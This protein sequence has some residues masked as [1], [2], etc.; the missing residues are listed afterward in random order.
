VRIFC[1][2]FCFF[3]PACT[4]QEIE[5]K[6]ATEVMAKPSSEQNMCKHQRTLFGQ[7]L[8]L[9][10]I[11]CWLVSCAANP[12][13]GRHEL[14]LLSEDDESKLGRK[15]DAQ[16][17]E[18]YGLYR[19]PDLGAYIE[20]LGSGIAKHSHRSHLSFDFKVLDSST[21]NAFAV[22]GGYVYLTRGILSYLN[23]EA[24][25]V[26][27]IAHE[28]GHVAARHSAQQY[29]RAQLSQLGLGVG[30]IL[31]E[32][33]RQYARV[34]QFG[35]GMLFLKFSRDNE[36]QADELA[37]EYATKA[38][39]D[40]NR[41]ASFFLTLQRLHPSSD[42]SGLPN[43]FSTHP[44]P[45]DRIKSI[46]RKA[47]EWAKKSGRPK[48]HVNRDEYLLRID[49]LVLGEDPRQGYLADNTFYH[50]ELTF[51]FPV[52]SG[53]KL[54]NTP[55][56]IQMASKK[57]DAVIL[58]SPASGTS[59]KAAAR[60]FIADAQA[61]VLAFDA[62]T[63]NGLPAQRII[64]DIA[65]QQGAIRVMS[66]FI[67]KNA[68]IYVFHAFTA[69]PLFQ[70]YASVFSATLGG[71]K[72]LTDPKKINVK[73]DRLII[74][75]TKTTATLRQ[76]LEALGVPKED[77]EEVSVLNGR[78]LHDRIPADTLL[79]I[80]AGRYRNF[81]QAESKPRYGRYQSSRL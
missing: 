57:Q 64:A 78:P 26:G 38:G 53:W 5:S 22:P 24:E 66:Y 9:F 61:Q 44:D 68:R 11:L 72:T 65:T 75:A 58:F 25:L 47:R 46:Q 30:S 19:D 3:V 42:R 31:S 6:K 41:M 7:S 28:I 79:K 8:V 81:I 4:G 55:S 21:V 62:I 17:A 70:R 27:V 37:V 43:W 71:F 32:S 13:T 69:P 2:S 80:R 29:S 45:P 54:N 14:M 67:Q 73:P 50:P 12:V 10:S 35:V 16:I 48:L 51:R 76:A 52:P 74:R 1:D 63:V 36:R 60:K 56:Q 59:P 34:A 20:T 18:T 40:A 77:L 39:F 49:G 15:T 23:S 33:F